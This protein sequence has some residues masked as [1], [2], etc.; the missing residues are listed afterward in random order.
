MCLLSFLSTGG[1]VL[2]GVRL[3]LRLHS[4]VNAEGRF[5]FD[6]NEIRIPPGYGCDLDDFFLTHGFFCAFKVGFLGFRVDADRHHFQGFV[7]HGGR[8]VDLDSFP[9]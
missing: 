3:A 5:R 2:G 9:R 1:E 6:N 8:D 7:L 4:V